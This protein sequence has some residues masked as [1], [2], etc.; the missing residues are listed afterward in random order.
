MSGEVPAVACNR[1]GRLEPATSPVT[2]R[3]AYWRLSLQELS[4]RAGEVR[5][6]RDIQTNR[7][8]KSCSKH[9]CMEF[10]VLETTNLFAFPSK[11]GVSQLDRKPLK[12]IAAWLGQQVP[13]GGEPDTPVTWD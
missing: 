5:I 2:G 9:C 1:E 7:L 6:S 8:R 12:E 3:P 13:A 11:F 10:I 4:D